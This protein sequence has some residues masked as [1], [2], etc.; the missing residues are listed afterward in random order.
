MRIGRITYTRNLDSLGTSLGDPVSHGARNSS[1]SQSLNN[2][3]AVNPLIQ[4]TV[5]H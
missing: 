1:L 5:S 3:G 4:L 2:T